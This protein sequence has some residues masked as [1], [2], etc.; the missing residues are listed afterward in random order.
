MKTHKFTIIFIIPILIAA[1]YGDLF[2]PSYKV[3]LPDLPAHWEEVL[4]EAH[5]QLEWLDKNGIWHYL[6]I[7]PGEA[8]PEITVIQ[9]WS[10]PI[11]AYPYWPSR[12]LLPGNFRPAAAIFPW[13]AEGSKIILSWRAGVEAVFWKE[14]AAAESFSDAAGGRLPWYLDWPRFRELLL[15]GNIP[16]EVRVN[17]W[18]ADW[19]DIAQRTVQ[20]GFYSSRIRPRPYV[21]LELEGMGDFWINS[22][23]FADTID[24]S[25]GSTLII[26][27]VN[28]PDTWVSKNGT[29]RASTSAWIFLQ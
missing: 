1:C 27:A 25:P 11:L 29:L 20:S 9:E 6:Y 22:S 21:E 13:D 10:S 26:R 14:L 3:I 24:Q 15:T 19:K 16:M 23:P 18:L 4:G 12:K 28:E 5:W 8:G 17:P 2:F 7:K